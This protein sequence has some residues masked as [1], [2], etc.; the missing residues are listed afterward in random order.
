MSSSFPSFFP[1]FFPY[2][3]LLSFSHFSFVFFLSSLLSTSFI[4]VSLLPPSLPPSFPP[5]LCPSFLLSFYNH[6]LSFSPSLLSPFILLP[7][8]PPSFFHSS[9]PLSLPS[10]FHPSFLPSFLPL[11]FL[12]HCHL[13]LHPFL[14][15]PFTAFSC[16]VLHPFFPS[17]LTPLVFISLSPF[18]PSILL[19]SF[20]FHV[21]ISSSV[22][23]LC[24]PSSSLPSSPSRL[25]SLP[26]PLPCLPPFLSLS[27]TP[28]P[29]SLLFLLLL[30]LCGVFLGQTQGGRREVL[31]DLGNLILV[32]PHFQTGSCSSARCCF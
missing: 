5:V 7:T 32:A 29:P 8:C 23:L 1:S 25:S 28:F 13:S 3:Q 19:H 6:L 4:F 24:S 30:F 20:I 22:L 14:S 9:P 15:S 17:L 31:G 10:L 2:I 11:I 21:S 26:P 27:Y 12:P 18:F 16:P